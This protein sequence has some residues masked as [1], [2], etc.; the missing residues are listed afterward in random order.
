M[1]TALSIQIL[2]V[3]CQRLIWSKVFNDCI[4]GADFDAGIEEE[5]YWFWNKK[6]RKERKI[7]DDMYDEYS[8][9]KTIGLS[10]V[11]KQE[12]KVNEI[13]AYIADFLV[14]Y[15]HG[16]K[17][18]DVDSD[19]DTE[20]SSNYDEL[21]VD[22]Q[23]D[24]WQ[25]EM[26]NI[27]LN[28]ENDDSFDNFYYDDDTQYEPQY[29]LQDEPIFINGYSLITTEDDIIDDSDLDSDNEGLILSSD[30]EL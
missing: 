11:I 20:Y 16:K 28:D 12:N 2:P 21:D 30:D 27:C 9:H 19:S 8:R 25:E 29:E 4:N 23:I 1:D 18:V 3:D 5:S 13:F 24:R 14:R 26:D 10:Q 6:M 17:W 7:F 15:E 22:A